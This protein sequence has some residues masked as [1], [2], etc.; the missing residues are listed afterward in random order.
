MA[1]WKEKFSERFDEIRE[2]A[3]SWWLGL[4]PREKIVLSSLAG[5]VGLLLVA[6]ILKETSFVLN[7]V[8]HQAESNY[9]NMEKI[10][11]WIG[12]LRN[13]RTSLSR[14]ERLKER[15][16]ETFDFQAFIESEAKKFTLT[17]AKSAPARVVGGAN[18]EKEEDWLQVE[19]KDGALE[20]LV[21]FM[22]GLEETLGLRLVEFTIK[23]QFQDP[24][25]M[26]AVVVVASKKTL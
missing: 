8:A 3:R 21:K 15:R 4:A 16:G 26:D 20:N 10:Q 11:N 23:T 18:L 2:R 9:K 1:A 5:L 17:L 14:Y 24:T 6:V 22:A 25:K 7:Q 13:Q 12:E 19:L